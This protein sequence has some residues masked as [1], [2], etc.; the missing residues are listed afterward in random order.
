MSIDPTAQLRHELRTPMNHIIGY[1][2]MLLAELPAADARGLAAGLSGLRADARQLL[3]L[4]IRQ[5]R[6]I[7]SLVLLVVFLLRVERGSSQN[8]EDGESG[9]AALEAKHGHEC[10]LLDAISRQNCWIIE[11]GIRQVKLLENLELGR[12]WTFGGS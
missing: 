6:L 8:A 4:L 11:R 9:K 2:E 12:H 1:A 3:T 5:L 7:L 10:I